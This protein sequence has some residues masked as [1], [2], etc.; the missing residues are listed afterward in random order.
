MHLYCL[1]CCCFCMQMKT[2]EYCDVYSEF[3]IRLKPRLQPNIGN[4]LPPVLTVFTCSR[5][6]LPKVNGFGWN[7]EHCQYIA[8]AWP[9]Q[10]LG[11]IHA[12][13]RV[14]KPGKILFFFCEVSNARTT[15]PISHPPN[16]TKFQHNTSICVAMN[17]VRTEFWK[18]SHKGS[19]FQKMQKFR[20]NFQHLP[21]S[22]RRNFMKIIDWQKFTTKISLYGMSSFHFF[23]ACRNARIASAVL[24]TAI[25]SVFLSVR[26]SVCHTPVLCQNDGT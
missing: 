2:V 19:F 10:I 20:K 13:A 15:S 18:F 21:T 26:P 7:L 17:S 3:I 23:T 9:W 25:P 14:G 22:G 4:T 11:T 12:V 16:F 1:G 6:T 24:A 8:C 5:I